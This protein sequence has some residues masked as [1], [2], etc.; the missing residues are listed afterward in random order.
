MK[1]NERIEAILKAS[2]AARNSDTELLIIYMQKSGLEL[3]PK[4][5]EKFKDLPSM[6]TITR[7]RRQLQEQGKYEATQ[8]VQEARYEKFKEHTTEYGIGDSEDP[9]AYLEK[10]GYKI[11]EED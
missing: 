2:K 10:L 1:I 7:V 3:T 6:E 5:I 11:A 9:Y 4:Q 8:E